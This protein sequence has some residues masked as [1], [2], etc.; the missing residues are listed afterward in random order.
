LGFTVAARVPFLV[1]VEAIIYTIVSGCVI[2]RRV[3]MD[4]DRVLPCRVMVFASVLSSTV[5]L[6]AFLCRA[7]NF[8]VRR[9]DS[10][11]LHSHRHVIARQG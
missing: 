2:L 4:L 1:A 7:S 11:G 3:M 8:Y 10:L 5:N 6:F 9:S